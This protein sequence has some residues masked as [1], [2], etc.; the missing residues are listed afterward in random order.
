[1]V[2]PE[3]HANKP[4]QYTMK[5]PLYIHVFVLSLFFV[6]CG[7]GTANEAPITPSERHFSA[8][9][10]DGKT[11]ALW[12]MDAPGPDG[13]RQRTV[14]LSDPEQVQLMVGL[15][16]A[17]APDSVDVD[18]YDTAGSIFAL[19]GILGPDSALTISYGP[20]GSA[21]RS[22]SLPLIND[23]YT[24]L[25]KVLTKDVE[26]TKEPT[27]MEEGGYEEMG[28]EELGQHAYLRTF[29][30]TAP[31]GNAHPLDGLLRSA[32]CDEGTYEEHIE[33]KLEG[34]SMYDC[35]VSVLHR[36]ADRICFQIS[37]QEEYPGAAHGMYGSRYFN[38][39]LAHQKELGLWD[40]ID[41]RKRKQLTALCSKAFYASYPETKPK[42]YPFKLTENVAVL[43]NGILFHYQPYE[44]GYFA[45]GE[46]TVFLPF[47]A[48]L[49]LQNPSSEVMRSAS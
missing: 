37:V 43:E 10:P 11:Y 49:E 22:L 26:P 14:S 17:K 15:S 27:P 6:S 45:E 33:R 2:Q 18:M 42:D 4:A 41:R 7:G 47:K 46:K 1:M 5:W 44:M 34:L 24:L 31:D 12:I 30:I 29:I 39:D 3:H 8:T 28:V 25:P 32:V 13:K 35:G 48:L 16:K 23:A 21:A 20:I 36:G 40:V 19:R 38:Y 9:T